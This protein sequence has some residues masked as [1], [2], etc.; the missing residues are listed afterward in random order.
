MEFEKFKCK[1]CKNFETFSIIKF[2]KH[3]KKEH[4]KKLTKNDWKFILKWH[5]ISQII[6]YLLA[7]PCIIII[8]I[9]YCLSYPFWYIKEFIEGG[10]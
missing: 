1:H 5:I 4:N 2:S 10:F 8:I 9:L 7:I 6:S 3:L